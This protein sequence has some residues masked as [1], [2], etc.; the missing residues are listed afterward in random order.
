[1]NTSLADYAMSLLQNK[2]RRGTTETA[3]D[4]SHGSQMSG[5]ALT[6]KVK[7][8]ATTDV[9]VLRIYYS[10]GFWLFESSTQI[11]QII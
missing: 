5:N 8:R 10:A 4:R 6:G 9:K 11:S 7:G 1:L 2:D 3:L